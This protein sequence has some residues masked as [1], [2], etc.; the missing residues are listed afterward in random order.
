MIRLNNKEMLESMG[1]HNESLRWEDLKDTKNKVDEILH[2][3][4]LVFT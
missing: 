4:C 2:I 3:Y 1:Y